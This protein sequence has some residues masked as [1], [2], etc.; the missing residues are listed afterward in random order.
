MII[1]QQVSKGL[2]IQGFATINTNNEESF[3]ITYCD[4]E[5]CMKTNSPVIITQIYPKYGP[6]DFQFGKIIATYE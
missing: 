4:F 2:N 6:C 1:L 3:L 5:L